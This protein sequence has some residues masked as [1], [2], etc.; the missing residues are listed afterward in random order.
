[1]QITGPHA[2]QLILLHVTHL[3]APIYKCQF[4]SI[5][6]YRETLISIATA[7]KNQQPKP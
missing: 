3:P 5:H 7:A 4:S 2:N 1:M 6:T